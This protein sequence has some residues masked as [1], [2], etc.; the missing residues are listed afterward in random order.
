MTFE[1]KRDI[2]NQTRI[3]LDMTHEERVEM[4]RRRYNTAPSF[5]Q[6]TEPLEK[7]SCFECRHS[8]YDMNERA[9][10]CKKY[11]I[12]R[13]SNTMAYVCDGLNRDNEL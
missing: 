2:M 12:P 6:K 3:S 9:S 4:L 10:M 1:E 8:Y 5:R 13:I 11:T 7:G